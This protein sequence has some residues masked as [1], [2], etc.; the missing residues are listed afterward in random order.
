MIKISKANKC[1]QSDSVDCFF[2]AYKHGILFVPRNIGRLTIRRDVELILP[3]SFSRCSIRI[4]S[5]PPSVVEICESCFEEC[6]FLEHVSFQTGS[7]LHVI[8]K[9]AFSGCSMLSRIRFPPSLEEIESEAFINCFSLE[10][11]SFPKESHLKSIQGNCFNCT[12]IEN[13]VLP[14]SLS[15]I[16]SAFLGGTSLKRLD[17]NNDHY[18]SHDGIILT[19]DLNDIVSVIPSMISVIIPENVRHILSG[20]FNSS[21]IFKIT[22]PK[23]VEV[24]ESETFI[25]CENLTEFKF[26]DNSM[27][28]SIGDRIV[29]SFLIT[30]LN[31]P[32]S[33]TN[34]HYNAFVGVMPISITINND[35]YKT[36]QNGVV[37]SLSPPGIV[38][39]PPNIDYVEIDPKIEIIFGG[40][41][42]RS[43]VKSIEFP[44]TLRI[45]GKYSFS[46]S[47]IESLTFDIDTHL[48]V[49]DNNAF[50][51]SGMRE[52]KLPRTVDFIGFQ[53]IVCDT[54]EIP[55]NFKTSKCNTYAISRRVWKLIISKTSIQQIKN[56]VN[57][58]EEIIYVD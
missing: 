11:V 56:L 40:C 42:R 29:T 5:I 20:S 31:L 7:K 23:N 48:E 15:H 26:E 45:I 8:R 2:T 36:E 47:L 18:K 41:F 37:H 34:I 32:S 39:C 44:S 52:L 30:K 10:R 17:I 9:K 28:R 6:K 53:S 33:V 4:L 14:V 38:F 27:L 49:L 16:G 19:H 25:Y 54:L 22:I 1:I 35:Y 24:I 58:P 55:A 50:D 12:K 21:S 51:N 3:G 46:Q 13:L 57:I 43:R